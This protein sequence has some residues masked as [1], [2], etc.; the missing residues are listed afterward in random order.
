MPRSSPEGELP[1]QVWALDPP[2]EGQGWDNT[3]FS[4]SMWD[5]INALR[6]QLRTQ[7]Q[8][9]VLMS[10]AVQG[11][12]EDRER[13]RC[14][15]AS[16]EVELGRLRGAPE[17][18]TRLEQRVEDLNSELQ[19]LRRQL[20]ARPGE[21]SKTTLLWQELQNDC[22]LLW[23]EYETVRGELK[24][25]RD[26]LGQQQE[27]LLRQM[28]EI[29]QAQGQNWKVLEQV[30]RDQEGH[31]RAMDA[32]R[33]EAQ[34]GRREINLIRAMVYSLQAQIR[35]DPPSR[36]D[37]AISSSDLSLPDS[38]SSWDVPSRE[39]AMP[40][41]LQSST[42]SSTESSTE[43]SMSRPPARIPPTSERL[44][45]ASKLLLSDL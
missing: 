19:N 33:V 2:P 6:S 10:Q 13:Q 31:S 16:L 5:E 3:C 41:D 23:E 15:I 4:L 14:Q 1:H 11:L 29:R 40:A 18:R 35:G 26:Q 32:T 30:Q 28:A 42:G 27:L 9:T 37:S 21:A 24:L 34:D 38:D 39:T 17:G 25:L 43:R 20:H 7:G 44:S 12:M 22:Q 45:K 8:V 36:P